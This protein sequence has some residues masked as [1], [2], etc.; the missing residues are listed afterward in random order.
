MLENFGSVLLLLSVL[1]QL[2]ARLD[3][4]HIIPQSLRF[5][6]LFPYSKEAYLI[7]RNGEYPYTPGDIASMYSPVCCPQCARWIQQ[8]ILRIQKRYSDALWWW[9]KYHWPTNIVDHILHPLGLMASP[10]LLEA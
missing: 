6:G 7:S 1:W 4:A 3:H 8:S 5:P 10:R 9:Q 2:V